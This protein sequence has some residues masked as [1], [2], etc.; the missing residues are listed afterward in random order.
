VP[1]V[2]L[3]VPLQGVRQLRASTDATR[4]LTRRVYPVGFLV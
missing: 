2:G 4:L 1:V 3:R